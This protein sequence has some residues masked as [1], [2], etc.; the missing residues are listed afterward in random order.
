[1]N[2]KG[3]IAWDYVAAII[4]A[5]I[6]ILI[7]LIFTTTLKEKIILGVQYLMETVLGR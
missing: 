3:D 1:M 6:V 2:T 5:L 4:I 7:I